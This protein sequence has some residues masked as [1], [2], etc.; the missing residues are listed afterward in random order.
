[1]RP[2]LFSMPFSAAARLSLSLSIGLSSGRYRRVNEAAFNER[3]G[4]SG[5]VIT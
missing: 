1:M 4:F 2:A 3:G 5:R